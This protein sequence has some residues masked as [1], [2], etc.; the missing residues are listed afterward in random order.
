[1]HEVPMKSFL[2]MFC[3][4]LALNACATA[5]KPAN[6]SGEREAQAHGC[7]AIAG[8]DCRARIHW[9][10]AEGFQDA[11]EENPTGRHLCIPAKGPACQARIAWSCPKGFVNG[12][13]T[14]ETKSHLCVSESKGVSC[15][16]EIALDCPE[17]FRDRCLSEN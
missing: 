13:V 2:V 3:V 15:A 14:G 10:C 12:C 5:Q 8:P 1:M 6:E 11:C 17:G 4:L 16:Q 7:V 9:P